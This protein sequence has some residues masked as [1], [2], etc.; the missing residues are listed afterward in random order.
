MSLGKGL[1]NWCQAHQATPLSMDEV[2]PWPDVKMSVLPI[3]IGNA[4]GQKV[5]TLL[6]WDG[7]A[8]AVLGPG[9]GVV[10]TPPAPPAPAT[11]THG[12]DIGFPPNDAN[13]LLAVARAIGAAWCGVYVG[14][15]TYGGTWTPGLAQALKG[16][17]SFLPIYVGANVING[18][19]QAGPLTPDNGAG[20]GADALQQLANYGFPPGLVMLDMEADTYFADPTN[21]VFYAESWIQAVRDGGGQAGIYSTKACIDAL[22]Q[23][24]NPLDATWLANWDGAD[25][26]EGY[27]IHQYAGSTQ[28]A[29]LGVD[30]NVAAAGFAFQHLP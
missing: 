8:N 23:R 6:G 18:V 2:Y 9:P 20:H 28:I 19:L 11:A 21:A 22:A 26:P 12:F 27:D 24:V 7:V 5:R 17:L 4:A 14:G 3:E 16:S 13:A 25:S 30:L 15:P 29:G 1:A 10:V